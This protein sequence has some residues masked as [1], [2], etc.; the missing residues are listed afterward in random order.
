MALALAILDEVSLLPAHTLCPGAEQPAAEALERSEAV[1]PLEW[2]VLG[3]DASPGGRGASCDP[4]AA[5]RSP[6]SRA[7][8]TKPSAL[9]I[10]ASKEPAD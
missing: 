6:A 1:A 8:L 5:A 2:L 9:P 10:S 4:A 7:S 3:A